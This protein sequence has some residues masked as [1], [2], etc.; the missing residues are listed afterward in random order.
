[1]SVLELRKLSRA[2]LACQRLR[3]HS[4]GEIQV[5]DATGRWRAGRRVSGGVMLRKIGW[6]RLRNHAGLTFGELLTGD[7]RTSHD[8]RRLQ[9]IWRHVG[10]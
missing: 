7:P 3:F 6:I 4:T 5:L 10:A 9:V 8:W 1:M 2:W